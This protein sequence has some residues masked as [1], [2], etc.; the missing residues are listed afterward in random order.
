MKLKFKIS[1]SL[2]GIVPTLVYSVPLYKDH[3]IYRN[4]YIIVGRGLHNSSCTAQ[5]RYQRVH[6]RHRHMFN[7]T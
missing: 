6:E 1:D 4:N 2:G 7:A 3:L 5:R